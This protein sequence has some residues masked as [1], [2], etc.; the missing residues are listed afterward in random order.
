MNIIFIGH[1]GTYSLI[2][3]DGFEAT[4]QDHDDDP[5]ISYYFLKRMCF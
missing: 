4:R 1:I 3:N 2:V 5:I